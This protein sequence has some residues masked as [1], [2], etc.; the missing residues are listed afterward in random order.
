MLFYLT[1]ANLYRDPKRIQKTIDLIET[2]YGAYKEII[3]GNKVQLEEKVAA[4]VQ[5]Q[6]DQPSPAVAQK[7]KP[8]PAAQPE[9]GRRVAISL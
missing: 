8:A 2:I 3:E 6:Q 4:A 5:S 9:P 7:P 1:E